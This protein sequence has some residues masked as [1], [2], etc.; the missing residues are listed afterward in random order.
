M[1]SIPRAGIIRALAVGSILLAA[2]LQP[3]L[4]EEQP[5]TLQEIVNHAIN[6]NPAVNESE[7]SGRRSQAVFPPLRRSLILKSD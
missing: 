3:V 7:K 4:A 1:K 2:S 6:H 5:M